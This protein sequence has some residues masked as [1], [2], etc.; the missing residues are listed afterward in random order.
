MSFFKIKIT[1][2]IKQY[3]WQITQV[4]AGRKQKTCE[5]CNKTIKIGMP[6]WTFLKKNRVGNNVSYNPR[7]SCLGNCKHLLSE[8]IQ[9]EDN[10]RL[11]NNTNTSTDAG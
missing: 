7:Y 1:P 2:V 9:K 4:N 11:Q 8:K 10:E 5:I 6:A 3:D